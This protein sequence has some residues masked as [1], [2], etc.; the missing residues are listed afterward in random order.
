MEGGTKIQS[1]QM[2]IIF[3]CGEV[4]DAMKCSHLVFWKEGEEDGGL[5]KSCVS[6][7]ASKQGP[8]EI[9]TA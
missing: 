3:I 4:K 2:L 1:I 8:E 7:S 5:G 6:R 9:V